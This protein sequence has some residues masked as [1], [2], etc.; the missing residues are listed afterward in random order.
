MYAVGKQIVVL[1]TFYQSMTDKNRGL[2]V[3][4]PHELV[5]L[6]ESVQSQ[7]HDPTRSDTVR[8]LLYDALARM[9]YLS[10]AE[11]KALGVKP[12]E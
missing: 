11:K 8:V 5:D 1:D 7:R 9:S 10:L 4:L 3:S 2:S 6:I 12:R